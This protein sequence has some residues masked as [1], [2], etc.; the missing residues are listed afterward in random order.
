M[1]AGTTESASAVEWLYPE[2]LSEEGLR[3]IL[4]QR[5]IKRAKADLESL[6]KDDLVELYNRYVLPLPQ[7]KYRNNRRGQEMT[8]KQI[9]L[10]KSLKR[11]ST[12]DSDQ[13]KTKNTKADLPT[14]G[15]VNHVNSSSAPTARLKPPPTL[16]NFEKKVVKLTA[17]GDTGS[18]PAS[19]LQVDIQKVNEVQE[20]S[21]DNGPSPA[22]K[23]FEKITWP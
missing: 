20:A 14:S 9:L 18:K 1:E 12:E 8:R 11:K 3:C 5:F 21:K 6:Q 13:P 4:G 17:S 7:R 16:I 10:D 23:K 2:L 19:S 22:K 15:L